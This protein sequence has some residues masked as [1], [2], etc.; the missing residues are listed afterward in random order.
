MTGRRPGAHGP[1]VAGLLALI[2][3]VAACSTG[4]GPSSDTSAGTIDLSDPSS[5]PTSPS[6]R[7][8]L[9][10]FTE[11]RVMV[12]RADGTTEEFCLL[13]ADEPDEWAQGLMEV[14]DLGDHDG[15]VFVFPG[16]R[17]GGFFMRNTPMPLSIAFLDVDGGLVSAT[18]MEPCEDRD[19]CPTYG[20]DGPYRLAVEV[21]QGQLA[22]LGLDDPDVTLELAGECAE[23]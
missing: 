18:D 19:G 11:V 9:D 10:G 3:L 2:L 8:L 21:P 22:T 5:G 16:D 15:M 20:A 14:V 4:G 23:V 7:T 17:D 12:V 1:V 13:L 6:G